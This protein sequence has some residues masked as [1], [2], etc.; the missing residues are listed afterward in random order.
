MA[1]GKSAW[2]KHASKQF[3]SRPKKKG[4]V[5]ERKRKENEKLSRE[6]DALL[7]K[8]GFE[9][10]NPQRDLCEVCGGME[11]VLIA[12]VG[13]SILHVCGKCGKSY[14]KVF[15]IFSVDNGIRILQCKWGDWKTSSSRAGSVY[16]EEYNKEVREHFMTVA[17]EEEAEYI[18][19]RF[20]DKYQLGILNNRG[21]WKYLT[22][23]VDME[24]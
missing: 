13:D 10:K 14:E 16:W 24:V 19:N 18:F 7:D 21:C 8:L 23:G 17:T 5:I 20:G 1:Q 9:N 3:P 12:F 2:T 11:Q 15:P 4:N 6:T 22:D